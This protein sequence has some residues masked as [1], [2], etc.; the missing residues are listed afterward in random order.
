MVIAIAI[1]IGLLSQKWL[2]VF[3]GSVGAAIV[4]AL[5][6]LPKRYEMAVILQIPD[7]NPVMVVFMTTIPLVLI[8][9]VTFGL[10]TLYRRRGK[11]E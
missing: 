4:I 11:A 8:A 7:P 5:I 1:I 6:S 3:A 10:K 9:A 2:H